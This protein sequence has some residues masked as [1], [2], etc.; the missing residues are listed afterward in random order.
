MT[1]VRASSRPPEGER[2]LA[3]A[4]ELGAE[5]AIDYSAPGWEG[6]VRVATGGAG[7]V[8]AFD[9]AGGYLGKAVFDA[10]ADGGRFLT[11]GTSSGGF[12][13][14]D[15]QAAARRG[16]RVVNMLEAG[17]PGPA[18]VRKLLSEALALTAQGRIR[19][20]IGATYPL[21]RAEDAHTSLAQRATVG[22]SLLLTARSAARIGPAE[23]I[24]HGRNVRPSGGHSSGGIS[25]G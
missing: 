2:K 1:P 13:D 20:V 18:E 8:L 15:P 19:P 16:V 11:Y 12:A 7:A 5:V 6:Q 25:G 4:R 22:K 10:V 23:P 3:L 17:S 9:G 24:R 14:I 21:E